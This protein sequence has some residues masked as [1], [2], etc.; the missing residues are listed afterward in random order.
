MPAVSQQLPQKLPPN[1]ANE[2]AAKAFLDNLLN[3]AVYR[4][5]ADIHF[6]TTEDNVI[7]RFRLD[8]LLYDMHT[9]DFQSAQSV[10]SRVKS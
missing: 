3:D 7:V 1:L 4:N 6:E 9:V 10:L 8:G 2:S 5:V